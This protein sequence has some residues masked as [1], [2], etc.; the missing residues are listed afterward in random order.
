MPATAI[1]FETHATT[2]D[3]RRR[4]HLDVPYP[5][6]ESWRQAVARVGR[7]LADPPLRW[8][9]Q[10]ILVIGHVATRWAL[11]HFINGIPLENLVAEEFAWQEGWEYVLRFSPVATIRR[12]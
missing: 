8:D 2:V 7:F 11:D 1:V 6:G 3:T 4:E 10:R 12:T 9:G 5:G